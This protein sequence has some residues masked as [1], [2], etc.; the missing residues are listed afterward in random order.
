MSFKVYKPNFK[1]GLKYFFS[2]FIIFIN[3]IIEFTKSLG[4]RIIIALI[5]SPLFV[6]YFVTV[7]LITNFVKYCVD[8]LRD[9]LHPKLMNSLHKKD[10]KSV[11]LIIELYWLI[12][13][14]LIC[15]LVILMQFVIP[16]I[17]EI[18]T[19][20]KIIFQPVLYSFLIMSV[21]FYTLCMPFEMIL[22]G[23]NENK[24]ILTISITSIIIFLLLLFVLINL[25]SINSLGIAIFISEII[26]L[27]HFLYFILKIFKKRKIYF[28]RKLFILTNICILNTC[29]IL[30]FIAHNEFTYKVF[31]YFIISQF[32]IFYN[33][34]KFR[35]QGI[36]KFLNL[37]LKFLK[38]K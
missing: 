10:K 21:L 26:S 16:Q 2:S 1:I 37:N 7:R 6:T 29:I 30:T 13:I 4:L 15:P 32:L 8:S 18:W 27:Y 31:L 24:S 28:N 25:Y 5:F 34:N 20:K 12:T 11:L 23:T 33:F 38:N 14:F 17:F 9:P 35:T 3:L 22:R 19:L 36:I